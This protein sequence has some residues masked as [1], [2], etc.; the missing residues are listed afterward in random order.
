MKFFRI[1]ESLV[2]RVNNTELHNQP[3]PIVK[4]KSKPKFKNNSEIEKITQLPTFE[5]KNKIKQEKE[6][7]KLAKLK[8][9]RRIKQE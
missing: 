4:I 2:K 3:T 5:K 6:L 1:I 7:S 8:E 9:K